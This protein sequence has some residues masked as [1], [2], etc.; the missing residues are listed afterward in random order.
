MLIW[1][2]IIILT[3]GLLL[4]LTGCGGSSSSGSGPDDP[5]PEPETTY[6][7]VTKGRQVVGYSMS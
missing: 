3:F 5:D 6:A 2:R 4:L 1:E 7:M